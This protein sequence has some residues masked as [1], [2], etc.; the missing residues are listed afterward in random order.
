MKAWTVCLQK[1]SEGYEDKDEW[2]WQCQRWWWPC[3]YYHQKSIS[4]V[5]SATILAI[6][7]VSG[8]LKNH[9][10]THTGELYRRTLEGAACHIRCKRLQH[11][12]DSDSWQCNMLDYFVQ[13]C[14]NGMIHI[15]NRWQNFTPNILSNIVIYIKSLQKS[16]VLPILY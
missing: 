12:K 3:W 6:V 15:I 13:P 1:E 11:C 4:D 2:W 16:K 5:S 10:L 9:K 14:L 7:L 8:H